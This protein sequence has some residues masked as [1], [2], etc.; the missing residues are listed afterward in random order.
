MKREIPS[1]GPWITKHELN[2]VSDACLNG[3]YQNWHNY[4]DRF[5]EA[6]ANYTNTKYAIAT[7]SCTGA[8]H[9][10]MAALI[11]MNTIY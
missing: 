11:D 7:S 2:Y 10:S 1:G 8:L 3:W 4:L 5:E 9:L 6:I